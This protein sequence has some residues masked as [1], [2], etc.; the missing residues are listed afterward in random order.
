MYGGNALDAFAYSLPH[1]IPIYVSSDDACAEWHWKTCRKLDR[2]DFFLLSGMLM[3]PA[4][5][6]VGCCG[7]VTL[8]TSPQ[9]INQN[10]ATVTSVWE[11]CL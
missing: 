6:T 10:T 3:L 11:F 7:V 8:P 9:P 4:L 5:K 2:S 1:G